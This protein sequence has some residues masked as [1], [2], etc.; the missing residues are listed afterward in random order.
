MTE[1]LKHILYRLTPA[2]RNAYRELQRAPKR[3]V[4]LNQ[5]QQA[6][7]SALA[8]KGLAVEGKWDYQAKEIEQ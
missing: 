2:Q 8:R 5:L 3:K 6:T 4:G 7:Y 1:Q